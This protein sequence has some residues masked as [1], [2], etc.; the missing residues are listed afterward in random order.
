MIPKRTLGNCW[1]KIFKLDTIL[2]TQ[3][4]VSQNSVSMKITEVGAMASLPPVTKWYFRWLLCQSIFER[5]DIDDCYKL[6]PILKD[7][8]TRQHFTHGKASRCLSHS[9]KQFALTESHCFSHDQTMCSL[10]HMSSAWSYQVHR[11]TWYKCQVHIN[12]SCSDTP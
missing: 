8:I 11:I 7:L 10:R 12:S 9:T 6:I 2:V 1:C 3:Q 5:P 4:V